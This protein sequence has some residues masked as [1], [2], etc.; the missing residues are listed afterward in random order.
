MW[1]DFFYFTKREKQGIL[2]VTIFI[3]GIFLGKY[4]FSDTKDNK[5]KTEQEET[6]ITHRDSTASP[7]KDMKISELFDPNRID[8][9]GMAALGIKPYVINNIIKYRNKGGKFKQP[10]DLKKIYGMEAEL[11][12]ELYPF[13]RIENNGSPRP[14]RKS[15]NK[16]QVSPPISNKEFSSIRSNDT[17]LP[18]VRP[19]I[20]KTEKYELGIKVDINRA[21][22]A[23][24]KK[25]PGIGKSFASRILKYRQLV[26]GFYSVEQIKEVYGM[27]ES[28]YDRVSQWMEVVKPEIQPIPVN[29]SSLDRLKAHPYINFYQAKSIQEIKKRK[30]KLNSIDELALL[31]EFSPRDLERLSLYLSFD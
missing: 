21:D 5:Q 27:D 15:Y 3:V 31:E 11:F 2:I 1:K 26:G 7:Q 30:G 9:S 19:A 20:P 25:I 14:S 4:F 10:E 13:I 8:S 24:L 23:E 29:S 22:T 18:E 16:S 17:K 6:E 12:T 28:L